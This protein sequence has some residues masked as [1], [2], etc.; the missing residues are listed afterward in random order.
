VRIL[1]GCEGTAAKVTVFIDSTDGADIWSTT[2]VSTNIIEASRLA[3]VDSIQ[4]KLS[5]DEENR[6]GI[7]LKEIQ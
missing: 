5:K 1:E 3:L 2:G 7:V 6:N 4:Y